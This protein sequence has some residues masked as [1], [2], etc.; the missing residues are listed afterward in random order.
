MALASATSWEVLSKNH[1]PDRDWK[2]ISAA[3]IAAGIGY[4]PTISSPLPQSV[5]SALARELGQG[6][7]KEVFEFAGGTVPA[8]QDL[9][10]AVSK[11]AYLLRCAGNCL[12]SGQPT[13]ASVD[14]YHFSLLGCRA[15]LSLLGV[16]VVEVSGTQCVLDIFPEGAKPQV[17]K[18]FR[19]QHRGMSYP[20]T[21]ICRTRGTQ[22]QQHD[23]WTI[24]L[25]V[26]RVTSF[27]SAIMDDIETVLELKEGFSRARNDVMYGNEVWL[28][29]EDFWAPSLVNVN[30]DIRT[31][32][33]LSTA[34]LDERDA[35]FAFAAL[36]AR[37]IAALVLDIQSNGGV[38][39]VPTSYG[40]CLQDFPGFAATALDGLYAGVFKRECYSL[41]I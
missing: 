9:S 22:I 34:F 31:Y 8:F 28:Y 11:S 2:T 41:N 21:L 18:K 39:I 24:L 23:M 29:E 25:R 17:V 1:L 33:S 20:A 38:D 37:I 32:A 15:L 13:W 40:R 27:P 14:A 7:T 3:W 26:L 6:S 30:D 4:E 19:R 16:H 12:V 36:L 35:N 10:V 5:V